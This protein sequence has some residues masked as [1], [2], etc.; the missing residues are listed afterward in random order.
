M[1]IIVNQII[2]NDDP[3]YASVTISPRTSPANRPTPQ[4]ITPPTPQPT[5]PPTDQPTMP[6][7]KKYPNCVDTP[8]AFFLWK[9]TKRGNV[10]KKDCQWLAGKSKR[11]RR[12]ICKQNE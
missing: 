7:T 5:T 9:V 1:D 8:S 12:D 10:K 3:G 2:T 4:P 6:P 11:K